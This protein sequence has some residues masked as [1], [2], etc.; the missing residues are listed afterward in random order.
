MAKKSDL[1]KAKE[2]VLKYTDFLKTKMKV[3]KVY[4]FGSFVKKTNHIDSDI[5]VAVVSGDFKDDSIDDM[6]SLM[7]LSRTIDLRI[8][9][10]PFL[11]KDFNIN[12]N[13]SSSLG[14]VLI[15][16]FTILELT[17]KFFA[18]S[19][20]V[21]DIFSPDT[22]LAISSICSDSFKTFALVY[23]LDFSISLSIFICVLAND[24]T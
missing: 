12:K 24:A 13:Y 7:K 20:A 15:F 9:P 8:E 19:R 3:K 22:I 4:L 23:V 11:P 16:Y 6:V 21:F 14:F 10:H 17:I 1:A 2:T 5:D 18:W